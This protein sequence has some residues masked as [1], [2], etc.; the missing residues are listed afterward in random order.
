MAGNPLASLK[1]FKGDEEIE[2]VRT[3]EN[4]EQGFSK[5]TLQ[6]TANRSDN[7]KPYVCKASNGAEPDPQP[8]VLQL[9]VLFKASQVEITV[10]PETPK[11]GKKVLL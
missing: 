4:P 2:G 1:W 10:E 11:S 5:S 3:E 9:N 6:I 7:D 8:A